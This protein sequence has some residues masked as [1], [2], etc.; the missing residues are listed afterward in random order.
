M[1]IK[2]SIAFEG[3]LWAS[4]V[5]LRCATHIPSE[6]NIEPI[7]LSTNYRSTQ[8]IVNLVNDYA[9]LD[10]GYQAVRV[11]QKPRLR[12][13]PGV[14]QGVPVLGMFRDDQETLACDLA[15]FVQQV[16][17]G[18]G[19]RLPDG[20]VIRTNQEDGNLGDCALLCSSPRELNS[21]GKLRLPLLLRQD[22]SALDIEVFTPQGQDLTSIS[23]VA[24]FGNLL[25]EC[26]DPGGVIAD[27]TSGLSRSIQ[28]TFQIWRN[29]ALG[30]AES[31]EATSQ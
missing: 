25:L 24:Q 16:F 27:Q 30:F 21:R 26:L 10:A 31:D 29:Q 7:F 14:G 19:F 9:Q 2:A 17:R 23:I 12:Y 4:S 18:T 1:M 20:T 22:L 6:K 8:T 28:A 11:A 13:G 5:I 15:D 3:L